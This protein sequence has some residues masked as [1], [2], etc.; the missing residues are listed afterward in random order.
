MENTDA[1]CTEPRAQGKHSHR[2]IPYFSYFCTFSHK[3]VE[4]KKKANFF[5]TFLFP[6]N[7]TFLFLCSAW[8]QDRHSTANKRT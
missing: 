3:L 4:E 2:G 1:S 7:N 8:K 6:F 5:L